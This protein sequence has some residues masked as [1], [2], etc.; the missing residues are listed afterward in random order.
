MH[1]FT[2]QQ[3]YKSLQRVLACIVSSCSLLYH[4][5]TFKQHY[6]RNRTLHSR[7]VAI[8]ALNRHS[9]HICLSPLHDGHHHTD[10]SF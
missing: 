5:N 4:A 3:Y 6:S 8:E 7:D 9:S 2:L 10:T 1:I